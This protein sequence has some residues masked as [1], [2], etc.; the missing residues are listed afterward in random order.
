MLPRVMTWSQITDVQILEG[1]GQLDRTA[2]GFQVVRETPK[3]THLQ[4]LPFVV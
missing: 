4:N 3:V 1:N 2:V